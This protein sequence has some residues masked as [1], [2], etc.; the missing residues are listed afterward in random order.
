MGKRRGAYRILV[1]KPEE[2]KPLEDPGVYGWIIFKR[3]FR[4]WGHGLD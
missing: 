4:T 2:K 3:I 1:G